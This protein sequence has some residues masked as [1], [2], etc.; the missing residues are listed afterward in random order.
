MEINKMSKIGMNFIHTIQ[1][2]D[3]IIKLFDVMGSF[4]NWWEDKLDYIIMYNVYGIGF[5]I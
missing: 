2:H 5:V 3:E 4:V 1:V